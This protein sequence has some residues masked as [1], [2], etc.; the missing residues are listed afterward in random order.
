MAVVAGEAEDRLLMSK[1][2]WRQT[3]QMR[4]N[5]GDV[6]GDDSMLGQFPRTRRQNRQIVQCGEV[7]KARHH[8]GRVL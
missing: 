4:L 7:E 2:V 6:V 3:A 5:D 8:D 1:R